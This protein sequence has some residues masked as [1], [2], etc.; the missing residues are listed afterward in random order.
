MAQYQTAQHEEGHADADVG[1]GVAVFCEACCADG[2]EERVACLVGGEAGVVG[3]GRG[4][5]HARCEGEEEEFDFEVEIFA[6]VF[7]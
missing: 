1:E 7:C 5:L 3:P 2:E 6:D 4:V